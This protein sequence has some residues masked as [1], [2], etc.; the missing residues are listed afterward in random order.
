MKFWLSVNRRF[1]D[2]RA[3]FSCKAVQ[4]FITGCLPPG[5]DWVENYFKRVPGADKQLKGT[6]SLGAKGILEELVIGQAK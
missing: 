3:D 6:T 4:A 5:C 1:A 2:L